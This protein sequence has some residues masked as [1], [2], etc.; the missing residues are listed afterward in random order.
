MSMEWA[1]GPSGGTPITAAELNRIESGLP[2][3]WTMDEHEAEVAYAE[4]Q[5]TLVEE[6]TGSAPVTLYQTAVWEVHSTKFDPPDWLE[7][8]DAG[9]GMVFASIIEPGLYQ[10]FDSASLGMTAY[11]TP[12]SWPRRIRE[13]VDDV[14]LFGPAWPTIL[15]FS[16]MG[17]AQAFGQLIGPSQDGWNSLGV[18]ATHTVYVSPAMLAETGRILFTKKPN[19]IYNSLLGAAEAGDGNVLMNGPGELYVWKLT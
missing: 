12:P 16:R 3:N 10:F 2:Y 5:T 13:S 9:S 17:A 15:D 14:L 4:V 7:V 19:W 1:D 18:E 8:F 6:S 11:T